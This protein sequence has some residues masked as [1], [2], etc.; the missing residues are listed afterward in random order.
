MSVVIGPFIITRTKVTFSIPVLSQAVW[1][2]GTHTGHTY[3]GFQ[4]R[5]T[6][7]TPL[8]IRALSITRV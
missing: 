6:D 7:P 8:G 4:P 1:I 5:A 2:P 3:S